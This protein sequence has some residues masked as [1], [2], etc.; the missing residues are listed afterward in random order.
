M[1]SVPPKWTPNYKQATQFEA[2]RLAEMVDRLPAVIWDM[3]NSELIRQAALECF[4]VHV[5]TLIEF[6][7]IRSPDPRDRS[8]RD[9]L[10][11]TSWTPTLDAALRARLDADWGI[12]SQHLVHFSKARVVD[13]TG[14]VVVP[15]TGVPWKGSPTMC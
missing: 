12:V 7:G 2:H 4:F 1:S 3:D 5:R 9:T 8:A 13:E 6:L 11:N 10:T 15:R 14:H